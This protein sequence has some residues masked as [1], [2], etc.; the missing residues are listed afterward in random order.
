MWTMQ[1]LRQ[2]AFAVVTLITVLD[3]QIDNLYEASMRI[4]SLSFTND[5]GI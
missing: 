5:F 2:F 1:Y 3:I 4:S